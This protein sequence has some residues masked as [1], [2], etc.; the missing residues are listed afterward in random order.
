[1]TEAPNGP[2]MDLGS[3]FSISKVSAM[4]EQI[5]TRLNLTPEELEQESLRLFLT[6]RL[7]LVESELLRLGQRY[8]IQTVT[9]LDELVQRGDLH[10]DEAFE[11]YFEFDHLTAERDLLLES[12]K[13]LR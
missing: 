2:I 4:Y 5:A 3:R 10:E 1:L 7:R 8:G 9:Q 11:D 6:H 12:L 13:E